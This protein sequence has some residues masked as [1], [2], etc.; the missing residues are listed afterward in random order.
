MNPKHQYFKLSEDDILGIIS[1]YLSEQVN[2]GTF[3]SRIEFVENENNEYR[4]IAAYGEIDDESIDEIDF[5]VLDETL[6][7]NGE[8]STMPKEFLIDITNAEHKAKIQK[9][10]AKLD[11][12]LNDG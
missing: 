6:Q 11:T 9:L 8:R 5:K 3:N 7:F 2:F 12:E 1:D 10:I 4:I